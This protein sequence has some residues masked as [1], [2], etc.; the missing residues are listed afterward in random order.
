[1]SSLLSHPNRSWARPCPIRIDHELA[2]APFL[3]E[4]NPVHALP[5][6]FLKIH[7]NIIIPS[8]P[9][10]PKWSASPSFPQQNPAC[11]YPYVPNAPP[12]PV[13]LVLPPANHEDYSK[14]AHYDK[15]WF[16]R[17]CLLLVVT[18]SKWGHAKT[19]IYMEW[20][21]L[22]TKSLFLYN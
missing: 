4:I 19:A 22:I 15:D 13:F 16:S 21:I 3:R 8:T 20:L 12:I 9:M 11:I 14:Q 2:P 10:S 18:C 5:S 7:F 17:N 6:Y 1:M